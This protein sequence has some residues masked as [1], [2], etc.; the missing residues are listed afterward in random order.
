MA[1]Y[2]PERA[3]RTESTGRT[4]LTCTV[5][6]SGKLSDCQVSEETPADMGFGAATLKLS[7]IFKLRPKTLDGAPVSGGTW[8]TVI[9]WQ[10]PKG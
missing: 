10:L 2:Y 5:L 4:K 3:S 1:T 8:T 7:K 9:K 6:A